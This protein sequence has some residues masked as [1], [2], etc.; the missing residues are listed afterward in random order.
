MTRSGRRDAPAP[1]DYEAS[2]L[3]GRLLLI[4]LATAGMLAFLVVFAT[5]PSSRRGAVDREGAIEMNP[6]GEPIP[7]EAQ[8]FRHQPGGI[9]IQTGGGP[10]RVAHPR[11]LASY[12]SRRAYPGAPPRIPHGLTSEEYRLGECNTC[13]ERGG[14]SQRFGTFTRVTPHP[15]WSQCLQCHAV[16][17]AVVGTPLPGGDPD[18]VCAQCHAPSS[19]RVTL[20]SIDWRPAQWPALRGSAIAGE[21]PTIPHDLV[22]RGNC[23][24]CHMGPGAVVGVRTLHP[25]RGNCRQ[26]HVPANVD[27]PLFTRP[28]PVADSTRGSP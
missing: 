21:P 6:T 2:R 19:R 10:T 3:G 22:M 25:E 26:C 16:D 8:V 7:S 13:H 27:V 11:T 17:A 12:R 14:Y 5:R 18:A 4:A 9:V 24:A 20:P 1:H 15:E 23:L 28:P